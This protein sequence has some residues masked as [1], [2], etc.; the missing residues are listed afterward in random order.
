M[1][2]A[3]SK[4]GLCDSSFIILM[5]PALLCTARLTVLGMPGIVEAASPSLQ[6]MFFLIQDV[7]PSPD[8]SLPRKPAPVHYLMDSLHFSADTRST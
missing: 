4:L 6:V 1:I 2:N 7:C 5:D 3:S 8:C